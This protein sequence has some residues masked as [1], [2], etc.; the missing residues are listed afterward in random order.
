MYPDPVKDADPKLS[1]ALLVSNALI[2][3]LCLTSSVR[4]RGVPRSAVLLAISLGLPATG[5]VLATGPLGLLRHRTRPRVFGVP[6]A[7]LLG[8]YGA[9]TG[10]LSIAEN[11][12]EIL[13][14]DPT[15]RERLLPAC[16]ALVGTS[17]DLVLDPAGLDAGLWEWNGEGAYAGEVEGA[18]GH[19]GVPLVNYAGWLLLVGGAVYAY[20][21]LFGECR[22]AGRVPAL[23]LLPYYL[24]AAAW[25]LKSRRFR[26]LLYSMPF[27]AAVVLSSWGSG[28]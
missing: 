13:P 19:R 21:R 22:P 6:L 5:E 18:N 10:S 4:T 2:A 7:V 16:A 26:Y 1:K 11:A 3:A 28:R 9:I 12:L 8:W 25:A 17:L 15:S 23:L 14:L 24:A 27:P 20:A